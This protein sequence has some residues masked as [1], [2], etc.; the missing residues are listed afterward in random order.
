MLLRFRVSYLGGNV[1]GILLILFSVILSF[2]GGTSGDDHKVHEVT[3]RQQGLDY[4]AICLPC[5]FGLGI[6]T[7]LATLVRLKRP[8]RLTTA[9][10]C[11]YQNT[12]I[13]TSAALSL[14]S[15][16]ELKQAMRVSLIGYG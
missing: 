13:A 3:T 15:G 14:F 8:E 1:S 9:V 16:D 4:L 2:V 7:V 12:G 10:E 5:L 6:A 11:C